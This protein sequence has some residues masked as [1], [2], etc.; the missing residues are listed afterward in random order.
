MQHVY[1]FISIPIQAHSYATLGGGLFQRDPLGLQSPRSKFSSF[2]KMP[3]MCPNTRGCCNRWLADPSV[4]DPFLSGLGLAKDGEW[5]PATVKDSLGK[6]K[7]VVEFLGEGMLQ[8]KTN[9]RCSWHFSIFSTW[10]SSRRRFDLIWEGMKWTP[11]RRTKKNKPIFPAQL[12]WPAF[13]QLVSNCCKP[14]ASDFRLPS[15][16]GGPWWKRSRVRR[17]AQ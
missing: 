13:L 2:P 12:K 9:I 7:Y 11:K 16:V 3:P 4:A 17:L 6:G 14:L 10:F 1:H 8:W 15:E 5:Y